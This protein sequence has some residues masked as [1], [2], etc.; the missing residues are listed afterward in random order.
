MRGSLLKTAIFT[1]VVPGTVAFWFPLHLAAGEPS[2]PRFTFPWVLGLVPIA[3][4][5]AVYL[6][7]AW[8]FAVSGLGTPAP[9]DPPK[10]LVATGL[11]RYVRNPMY[12]GVVAAI[13]G[14]ALLYAS[15]LLLFYGSTVFLGFLLFVVFYEE[16]TL[17]RKFGESYAAYRRAVPRFLPRPTPWTP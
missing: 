8:D 17:A 4:G 9:I 3:A 12:V 6:R 14:E 13:L 16:P 11:Y 10:T 5:L 7:C 2:S 1:L 15:P